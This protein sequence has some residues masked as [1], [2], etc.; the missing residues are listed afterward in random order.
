MTREFV[1]FLYILIKY[2]K[3]NNNIFCHSYDQN[4]LFTFYEF[5]SNGED[6]NEEVLRNLIYHNE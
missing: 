3:K 2:M 1:G 4:E 6:N 5:V